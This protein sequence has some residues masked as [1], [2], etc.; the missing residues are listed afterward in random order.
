M[1]VFTNPDRFRDRQKRQNSSTLT[2]DYGKSIDFT[3]LKILG[4]LDIGLGII[5]MYLYWPRHKNCRNYAKPRNT[6]FMKIAS[7]ASK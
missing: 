2:A 4:V 3:S 1:P 5:E 6:F 7:R